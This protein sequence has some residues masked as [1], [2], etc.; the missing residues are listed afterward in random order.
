MSLVVMGANFK[1]APLWAREKL[2]IPEQEMLQVLERLAAYDGVNE[3]AALGTC[4]RTEF[5]I[6]AKTDRIAI[7]SLS[8]YVLSRMGHDFHPEHFYIERGDDAAEHLL[9]VVC[10][11]DSQVLGEAQILGQAKRAFAQAT[12]AGTCG[13]VLTKL[14]KTALQLGKRV[15]T[16]TAIGQDSVSLSTAPAIPQRN[17]R[18]KS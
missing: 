12:Q 10:S 4:N 8:D 13:V 3:A 5:Y 15:R 18:A 9:R 16:E 2:A 14:F 7:D 1:T 17:R 11:L 6:D